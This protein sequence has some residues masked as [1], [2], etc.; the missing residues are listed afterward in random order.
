MLIVFSFSSV[1]HLLFR[2]NRRHAVAS[3]SERT[4]TN[5]ILYRTATYLFG[6]EFPAL[7]F[8][9]ALVC[10]TEHRVEWLLTS[11]SV[12]W[13]IAANTECCNHHLKI[14]TTNQSLPAEIFS[15]CLANVSAVMV[16]RFF[17]GRRCN[18]ELVTRQSER[19]GH[20]HRL[21]QAFTEDVFIFSL[22]VYIVH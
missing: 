12:R 6:N 15:S 20:Q 9:D 10:F 8:A 3:G 21:L 11:A 7:V 5:S 19:S 22:L 4:S 18:M 2:L 16:G 14:D 17:C 1:F 13:R